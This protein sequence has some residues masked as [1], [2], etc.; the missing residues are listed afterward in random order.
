MA[1]STTIKTVKRF[2]AP[3]VII[4]GK[5]PFAGGERIAY[6]GIGETVV[7]RSVATPCP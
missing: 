4:D 3:P 5:N 7:L 1:D 2:M 6:L